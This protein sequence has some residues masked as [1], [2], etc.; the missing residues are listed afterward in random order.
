MPQRVMQ[1]C[2][3]RGTDSGE[4]DE[5]TN[6]CEVL[7]KWEDA[8]RDQTILQL[9]VEAEKVE[10]ITDVL[11]RKFARDEGFRVVLLAVEAV[12][13]RPEKKEESNN[14]D[15]G[16]E[17]EIP[18]GPKRLSRD[19]LY[20]EANE[21]IGVTRV[22]LG[23]TVL[24][25]MV[26]AVGLMRDDIAVIIGAMVLAPLLGPNVAM[27]LATTLGDM[28]LLRRALVTN[29]IGITLTLLLAVAAGMI[30]NVDTHNPAIA[31]RTKVDVGDIVLALASGAAGTLAFTR[32]PSSAVIGVMV[33]VALMPPLVTAGL[34]LGEGHERLALGAALLT[35]TNVICI[36]LAGI[37]TFLLQGVRPRRAAEAKRAQSGVLRAALIWIVMLGLLLLV[38]WLSRE[39]N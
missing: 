24:S 25:A 31:A 9:L 26:A 7:G 20:E 22:F 27:A 13:P 37:A 39:S 4:I 14:D 8:G 23:M 32:G 2:L 21:S 30:Y 6:G 12:L 11:E 15:G 38:L 19:E 1:I 17:E 33:A 10:P 3:P 18:S 29:A 16:S 35:G 28:Q 5:F 36:N 34:L